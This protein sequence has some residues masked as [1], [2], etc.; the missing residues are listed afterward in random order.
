M[1]D[2]SHRHNR[3]DVIRTGL[4]AAAGLAG[5][6]ALAA[7]PQSPASAPSGAVFREP[8]R[9][10]PLVDDA[11]VIVCGGGPA[12]VAAALASARAGAR[13]RLFE[14]HGCLG[15]IWTAGLLTYI[16][17]FDK[18]GLTAELARRLD[19]RS[20][21]TV[22][23]RSQFVYHPEQMKRL[24]EE[25]C[26]QAGVQIA[27]QSRVV[28]AYRDGQRL[29]TI[30]TESRSGRQAW[31]A[32]AFVD[33]TGDGDLGSQ[34]GCRWDFGRDDGACQ[35]MTLNA[36]IAVRDAVAL[37][38]CISFYGGKPVHLPAV[39]RFKAEIARAGLTPSYGH[40]TLFHI[41]H[42][43][44]LL[45]INH[46]YGVKPFEAAAVTRATLHARS[47]VHRVADALCKL[48][49]AWEGLQV[50]ASAEQIGVRDGRRIRGR[51]VVSR[52]DLAAGARHDDAV[53]RVTF[54]V[55]IHA[56]TRQ[57]NDREPIGRGGVKMKPYD[58]PLRAL[59]ASD[60]DGLLLAGRCISGDFV[61]HASYRVTGNSVATG[62]AAGAV[63]ALAAASNRPPHEVPWPQTKA[64]LEKLRDP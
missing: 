28:A 63:A 58:I 48:G 47:E 50:V 36:L 60:V 11:D 21:R 16:F 49:G 1:T 57:G 38:D 37:K 19:Q 61:A 30:V 35:P 32:K 56:P 5:A 27:L 7:G 23:N 41:R 54:G 31:R 20:A 9:D 25:M 6:D 17:D 64:M 8:A 15:G 45:M 43:L 4:A 26:L 55:D 33:A 44:L 2:S 14:L 29:T 22:V 34:A 24:L 40:P 39:E 18:P 12:G 13:T 51:Y 10:V 52:D 53:C 46:E 62:E 3:R 42:N 59:L